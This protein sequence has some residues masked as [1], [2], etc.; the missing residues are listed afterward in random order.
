M[1]CTI[2]YFGNVQGVGFR[3]NVRNIV[4]EFKISGFVRNLDDG[5]V[6]ILMEGRET[7]IQEAMREIDL[8]MKGLTKKHLKK[9]E[10]EPQYHDFSIELCLVNSEQTRIA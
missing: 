10:G 1:R 7:D 8:R 5:S 2:F 9:R 3:W 6:E 4:C